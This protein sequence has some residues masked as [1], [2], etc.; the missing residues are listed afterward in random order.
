VLLEPLLG[1]A[2]GPASAQF[3]QE[4]AQVAIPRFQAGDAAGALEVWLTGAFGAG[5]RPVLE[6]ALPGSWQVAVE[7]APAPFGVEL[8]SLQQ[9]PVGPNDLTRVGVP[10]LSLVHREDRWR[11][12]EETHELLF[13]RVPGCEGEVVEVASHLLQIADPGRVAEPVAAFL[14][15]HQPGPSGP[16]HR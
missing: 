9:W 6:R 7:D 2:L 13:A 4:T 1:F 16:I 12:F 14:S 8:P 5:F 15:R 11:G 3:I 10:T